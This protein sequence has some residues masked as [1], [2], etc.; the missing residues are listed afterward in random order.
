MLRVV[1]NVNWMVENVIESK[2]ANNDKCRN[3]QRL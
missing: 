1:L 3:E 2:K